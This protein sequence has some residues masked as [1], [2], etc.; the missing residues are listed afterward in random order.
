MNIVFAAYISGLFGGLGVAIM[1]L[2]ILA[3]CSSARIAFLTLIWKKLRQPRHD[4]G[5]GR[6]K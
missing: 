3:G 4:S 1:L 2:G 5:K 6:C